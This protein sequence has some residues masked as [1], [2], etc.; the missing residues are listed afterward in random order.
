MF[1]C[2]CYGQTS[3][4]FC[5]VPRTAPDLRGEYRETRY[6]KLMPS[7]NTCETNFR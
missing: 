1:V 5:P 7:A 6:K 3:I 2:F 4:F